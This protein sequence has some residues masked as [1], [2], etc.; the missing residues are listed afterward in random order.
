MGDEIV[1]FRQGHKKYLDA[2]KL[3]KIYDVNR[4]CEP[5]TKLE[6]K[7]TISKVYLQQIF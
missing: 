1:Y 3:K 4:S 7:V 2:V 6:L 5:W